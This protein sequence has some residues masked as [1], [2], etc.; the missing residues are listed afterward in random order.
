MS[1][2]GWRYDT[3]LVCECKKNKEQGTILAA[4]REEVPQEWGTVRVQIQTTFFLN[5]AMQQ[6]Q[7]RNSTSTAPLQK[8]S[9]NTRHT[10]ELALD[11]RVQLY[12]DYKKI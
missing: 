6:L 2:F 7:Q 9:N 10:S 8:G 11:L 4:T 3:A 12:V 5:A 1:L